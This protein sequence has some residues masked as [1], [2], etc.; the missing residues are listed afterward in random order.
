[1]AAAFIGAGPIFPEG[2]MAAPFENVNVYLM[3]A[4]AL[5]ITPAETDGDP[6]V[7]ETVTGGRCDASRSKQG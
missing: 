4:C 7:V 3:I 2:E 6:A 1:M 5:G